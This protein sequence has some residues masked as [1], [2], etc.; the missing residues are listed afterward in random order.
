MRFFISFIMLIGVL[1]SETEFAMPKP[2]MDNPRKIVFSITSGND[3]IIHHVLGTANNVLKA[4]GPE[5]VE[6]E[7]VAYSKGINMLLKNDRKI[8]ER[9]DTLMQYDVLFIACENTMRTK[10]I[11][12]SDLIDDVEIVTAG[13]VELVE[14]MKDGWMHIN[15]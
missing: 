15:P 3:E 13:V 8:A 7:I 5:N 14:R 11:K 2:S 10:N 12:K 6:M 1:F 9:V 4:Y